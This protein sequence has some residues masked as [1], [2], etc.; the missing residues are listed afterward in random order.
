MNTFKIGERVRIISSA[1]D[2]RPDLVGD[3]AVILALPGWGC[4]VAELEPGGRHDQCYKLRTRHGL[5]ICGCG[6]RLRRLLPDSDTYRPAAVS[7]DDLMR[8][9]RKKATV[10]ESG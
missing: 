4:P 1:P 9:A 7:I 10:N 3:E 5:T 2:G 6:D 8:A